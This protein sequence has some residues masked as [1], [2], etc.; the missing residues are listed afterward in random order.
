MKRVTVVLVAAGLQKGLI[1][2]ADSI[3]RDGVELMR[4]GDVVVW[5]GFRGFGGLT[6]VYIALSL[7]F[8]WLR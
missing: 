7:N 2:Y 5:Y 6:E 3:L 4:H 8:C 1:F